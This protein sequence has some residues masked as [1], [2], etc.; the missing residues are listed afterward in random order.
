MKDINLNL[1][2]KDT[3]I[4]QD[5]I[6]MDYWKIKT[7]L[8]LKDKTFFS[9]IKHK[10][11]N[12]KV[13]RF[14][15]DKHATLR[16]GLPFFGKNLLFC[17]DTQGRMTSSQHLAT[18]KSPHVLQSTCI[19]QSTIFMICIICIKCITCNICIFCIICFTSFVLY[20]RQHY[21]N[22][23]T[24]ICAKLKHTIATQQKF[25][26]NSGLLHEIKQMFQKMKRRD[27]SLFQMKQ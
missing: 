17:T 8:I 10:L 22:L 12:R 1:F 7:N 2:L 14:L 13:L 16:K 25:N 18:L 27:F 6:Y 21:K 15:K 26:F 24:M 19:F 3:I 20:Q 4:L 5:K 23:Y 9:I 11:Y